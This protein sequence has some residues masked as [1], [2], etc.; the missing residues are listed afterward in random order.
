MKFRG[1]K[2]AFTAVILLV[3]AVVVYAGRFRENFPPVSVGPTEALPG[4]PPAASMGGPAMM[5][6][7][8]GPLF[9]GNATNVVRPPVTAMEPRVTFSQ[10]VAAGSY[11]LMR[12]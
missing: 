10:P 5:A 2:F 11:R 1:K 7:P 9:M 6:P 12:G 8:P 4:P 3:I